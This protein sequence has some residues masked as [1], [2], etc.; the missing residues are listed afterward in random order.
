MRPARFSSVTTPTSMMIDWIG[1]RCRRGV[2]HIDIDLAIRTFAGDAACVIGSTRA[3]DAQSPHCKSPPGHALN[4]T[5]YKGQTVSITRLLTLVP[6][7][8]RI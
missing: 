2:F 8:R 5:I 1:S 7:E 6:A 3:R 4:R